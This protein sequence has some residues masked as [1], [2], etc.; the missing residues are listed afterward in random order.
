MSETLNSVKPNQVIQY[1]NC[2]DG[3]WVRAKVLSR[4]GKASK[5]SKFPHWW[6]IEADNAKFSADLS[7]VEE[8]SILPPVT[9]HVTLISSPEEIQ[10]KNQELEAWKAR[11]VYTEVKNNGQDAISL[12]WVMRTKD[13]DGKSFL[14]AGLCARGFEEEQDFRT[15]SPTCSREGVRL[16]LSI[17]ASMSWKLNSIDVKTAFLQ[18]NS[19]QREVLVKPPKEANTDCLW[20]LNKCV[21]G[22]ADAS[23]YWY[24]KLR[25]ELLKLDSKPCSLDQGIFVWFN[26]DQIRGIAVCFGD[27][28][29]G[30]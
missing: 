24:L 4:A 8:L 9:D 26:G 29:M 5:T 30:R 17:I 12:R 28:V 11:E 20:K 10:A 22:L 14:K 18:G 15:D 19:L 13:S 16:A 2:N 25:E 27:V 6:N 1:K 23:R 7:S 3:S 21:Y